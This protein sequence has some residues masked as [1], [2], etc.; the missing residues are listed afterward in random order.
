MERAGFAN[1]DL[2][3]SDD[4]ASEVIPLV[5][6]VAN[7][8]T[9]SLFL[10][11]GSQAKVVYPRLFPALTTDPSLS[12]V[13]L[14]VGDERLVPLAD[15]DSNTAMLDSIAGATTGAGEI[16]SPTR[17]F[18][19]R[20]SASIA[21]GDEPPRE[22]LRE[23]LDWWSVQL[24]AAPRPR[25]VHLGLGPDGHVASI[26]PH[27]DDL[28]LATP[29]CRV[30]LDTTGLNRHLRVSVT[31]DYIDGADLVILGTTG[32]TK[33][34]VLKAVLEDPASYPAGRLSPKRLAIV[35]DREAQAS[36]E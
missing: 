5:S 26:F 27:S 3:T 18:S 9:A 22:L 24:E 36:L 13:H 17:V 23:I 21:A 35:I 7:G 33:G 15:P 20:L 4:P 14:Y 16:V 25:I 28:G 34:A 11:G 12:G 1:F 29:Q 31:M 8:G 6:E 19:A 32:G 10:T 2:L 30:S